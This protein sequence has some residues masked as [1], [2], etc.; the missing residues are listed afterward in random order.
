MRKRSDDLDAEAVKHLLAA[1]QLLQE[2]YNLLSEYNQL[3]NI[4]G[5]FARD[6][7]LPAPAR[8]MAPWGVGLSDRNR[9][10]GEYFERFVK[11][12]SAGMPPADADP[13]AWFSR[14]VY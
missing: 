4:V 1:H 12:V 11:V 3:A 14:R 8:M 6:F 7:S 5:G 2:K 9:V 13:L 10:T